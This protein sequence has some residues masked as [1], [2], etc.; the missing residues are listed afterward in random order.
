MSLGVGFGIS[1][2]SIPPCLVIGVQDVNAQL[3]PLTHL[4]PAIMEAGSLELKPM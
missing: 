2:D 3:F 4:Y 1:K